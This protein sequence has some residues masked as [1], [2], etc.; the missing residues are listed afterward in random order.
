MYVYPRRITIR[1]FVY[2]KMSTQLQTLSNQLC[3]KGAWYPWTSSQNSSAHGISP[4]TAITSAGG[5]SCS[6]GLPLGRASTNSQP[7][8][9]G[10]AARRRLRQFTLVSASWRSPSQGCRFMSTNIGG[11]GKSECRSIRSIFFSTI[12]PT[13]KWPPSYFERHPWFTFFR[14]L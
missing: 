4:P 2:L 11:M 8:P 13:P 9:K 14:W 5:L 6:A 12:H 1:I 10:L 7:C 3:K